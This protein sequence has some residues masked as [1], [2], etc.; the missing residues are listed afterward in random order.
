MSDAATGK[1]K[2]FYHFHFRDCDYCSE[3]VAIPAGE[4]QMGATQDEFRG[5]DEKYQFMYAIET[6]RHVVKIKS[7]SIARFH[8]T[9]KQFSVF[10]EETGFSGKGCRV[11]KN[12]D[13]KFDADANWE[14]P[15]F[16]QTNS[17]PV[18][19]I[20]WNDARKYIGWLNEKIKLVSGRHY[21]LPSE[22]EWEYAA[23]AGTTT[24]TY[25]GDDRQKQCKYE[26]ARDESATVLGS[27]VSIAPCNDGY[28]WTSPVG[29]YLSNPWGLYDMLGDAKQWVDDCSETDYSAHSSLTSKSIET[30][31]GHI[32][33]GASWA[34]I[35]F[36]VR[37]ASRAGS[38]SDS[39]NST[40]GFRLAADL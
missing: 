40:N 18:V 15:G 3:M 28:I 6:P 31:L 14:N 38:S 13:W 24:S 2:K 21:R 35:P 39:R 9:R 27:D 17:D 12:G 25:W 23:R 33:R 34:A 37:S 32:L 22:E 1:A 10:A 19:C 4:Y 20:S 5:Q 29:S 36:A 16:K 30:C 11:F 7:F 8:V 26:N